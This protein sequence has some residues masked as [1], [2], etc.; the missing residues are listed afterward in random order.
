MRCADRLD[1]VAKLRLLE[2]MCSRH[3]MAWD[4]PRLAAIDLRYGD[5][6]DGLFAKLE[7]SGAVRTGVD[8]TEVAAARTQP[9]A[10]TRAWLRGMLLTRFGDR[11]VQA[12][13]DRVVVDL[14][15]GPVTWHLTSPLE[16]TRGKWEASLASTVSDVELL[17]LAPRY[18][19]R[20]E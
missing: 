2:A 11:V 3:G 20:H 14:G 16:G 17:S 18:A 13:W 19:G 10:S 1:W 4:D 9:P 5:L 15:Q 7:A 12:N 6:T 8:E